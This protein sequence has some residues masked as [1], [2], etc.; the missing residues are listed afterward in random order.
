[1]RSKLR[2]ASVLWNDAVRL[3]LLRII[4]LERILLPFLLAQPLLCLERC[5]AT[6][7]YIRN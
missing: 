1:M 7:T 6:G 3:T 2:V 5:N 4:F